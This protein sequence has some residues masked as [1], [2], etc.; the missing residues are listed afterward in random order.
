MAGHVLE[1]GLRDASLRPLA[2]AAGTS[3]RMLIYHFGSKE[4]LIEALLTHLA[5][6]LA[7]SMSAM[8]P[9]GRA[10]SERACVAEIM[11][12]MRQP[13]LRGFQR[14]W[15]EIAAE[16]VIEDG[17]YRRTGAAILSLFR[18]WLAARVPAETLV[19]ESNLDR[20]L[21]MIEG[22]LVLEAFGNTNGAS[23]VLDLL[24]ENP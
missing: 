17:A 6:T 15:F 9:E 14:V 12:T 16:A 22:M 13:H 7:S 4:S 3:D 20:L 8:V 23:A 5:E 24:Q 10:S 21:T 2:K 19:D 1:N 11:E 18:N